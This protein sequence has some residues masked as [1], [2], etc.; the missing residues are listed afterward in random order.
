MRKFSLL[1]GWIAF[2]GSLLSPAWVGAI[3]GQIV[4]YRHLTKPRVSIPNYQICGPSTPLSAT[5][6]SLE[7][8]SY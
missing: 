8:F 3:R 6:V 5:D 1:L 2:L 4:I 7:Q